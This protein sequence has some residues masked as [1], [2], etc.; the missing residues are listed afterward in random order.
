MQ[1]EMVGIIGG[2][3]VGD[4]VLA[5]IEDVEHREID[6]PFGRPSG[7]IAVGRLGARKVAF[8]SRHGRGHTL[9]PSEVPYAANVFALKKLGVTTLIASG[10]VGSLRENIA[11]RDLVVVDQFIDKTYRRQS[12]FFSGFAAVHCEF[13]HPC[14]QRLRSK[15]LRAA[16]TIDAVTHDKGVYVCMEGPQ[17]ST[18]AES[19][20]HRQWGGDLIGMTAMPEARLAREAQMCYALIALASDY[21]CWKEH[22]PAKGKQAL[23]EE[24]IANLQAATNNAAK[25]L[26][27]VLSTDG[28]LCDDT[29][30]CRRSLELAVWTGA[31]VIDAHKKE[32]LSVLF[33]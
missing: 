9:S 20:M 21:D 23:L 6:T 16:A 22:D 17:F 1:D 4:A 8:L 11:P 18:R 14:C 32:S 12:S 10:A 15:I 31:D 33:E 26:T 27:A 7:P 13:S 30:P 24:I 19:L 29:C 5:L 2:T 25:L 3:G 28:S